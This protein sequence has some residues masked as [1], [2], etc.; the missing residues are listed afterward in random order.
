MT[1]VPTFE[2]RPGE[3]DLGLWQP[4]HPPIGDDADADPDTGRWHVDVSAEADLRALRR[5]ADRATDDLPTVAGRLAGAVGEAGRAAAFGVPGTGSGARSPERELLAWLD[6]GMVAD[7][8]V[9]FGGPQDLGWRVRAQRDLAD[10]LDRLRSWLAP[11]AMV[12][13]AT[14]DRAVALTAHRWSGRTATAAAARASPPEL[15]LHID[16]V[17]LVAASRRTVVRVVELA[18]EG[19]ARIGSRLVLPGGPLLAL[20]ATWRFVHRVLDE[21]EG[22]RR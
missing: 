14:G 1:A 6:R 8:R 13:T 9:A 22:A 18:A 7:E 21:M 5:R 16:A 15:R 12:R 20:P 11:T 4:G 10:L 19:V 3:G 2:L 17:E